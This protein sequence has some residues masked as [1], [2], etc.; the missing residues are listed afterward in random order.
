[1]KIKVNPRQNL[2]S[3]KITQFALFSV[4]FTMSCSISP[5]A[6][7]VG[8]V[9]QPLVNGVISKNPNT[10][11]TNDLKQAGITLNANELNLVK[12]YVAV[13]PNGQWAA[14]ETVDSKKN[15]NDNFKS[16]KTTFVPNGPET[17]FTYMEKAI[18]FSNSANLYARFYFDTEYY[19]N[20]KKIL[21]IKWDTQTKEFILIYLDGTISNYQ[22]SAK[23]FPPRYIIIPE[24]L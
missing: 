6:P 5:V 7:N 12:Q 2:R 9:E 4:M 18:Q 3:L 22:V 23:I 13:R 8:N 20:R 17:E 15:L 21:V 16:F 24:I 11:F 14:T 19:K 10:N 1:M